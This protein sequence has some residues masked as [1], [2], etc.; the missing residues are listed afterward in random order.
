[1]RNAGG[2]ALNTLRFR[3]FLLDSNFDQCR[4]LDATETESTGFEEI[5]TYDPNKK[6]RS[7]YGRSFVNC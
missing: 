6:S 5:A 3:V 2:P 7:L 4:R 1:M